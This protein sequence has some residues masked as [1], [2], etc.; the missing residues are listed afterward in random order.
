MMTFT[1]HGQ[2]SST[3]HWIVG[4]LQECFPQFSYI[5]WLPKARSMGRLM[6]MTTL[7]AQALLVVPVEDDEPEPESDF[8]SVSVVEPPLEELSEPEDDDDDPALSEPSDPSPSV[9]ARKTDEA[10]AVGAGDDVGAM[11]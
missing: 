6:A 9:G 3:R 11:V 7:V 10:D 5:Q 1:N 4:T 8:P 2:I